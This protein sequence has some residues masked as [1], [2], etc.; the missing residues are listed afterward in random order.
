MAGKVRRLPRTLRIHE[1]VLRMAIELARRYDVAV[2][3]FIEALV[4]G[5]AERDAT[6][7]GRA[8][9][10]SPVALPPPSPSP[11][12]GRVIPIA[13]ARRRRFAAGES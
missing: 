13:D 8:L 4:V 3:D 7:A 5:C 6:A 2:E 11:G 1:A 9:P 10:D 12:P